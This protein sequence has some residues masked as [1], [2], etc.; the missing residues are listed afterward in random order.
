MPS[1]TRRVAWQLGVE[2]VII[3]VERTRYL[4]RF[5]EHGA[6]RRSLGGG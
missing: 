6:P 3:P 5:K 1:R 4:A 2:P